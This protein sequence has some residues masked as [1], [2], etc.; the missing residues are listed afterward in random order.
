[1]RMAHTTSLDDTDQTIYSVRFV[2]CLSRF[3]KYLSVSLSLSF[4][5]LTVTSWLTSTKLLD[6][7]PG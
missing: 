7:E 5:T 4:L 6:V 1:M 3:V 2:K